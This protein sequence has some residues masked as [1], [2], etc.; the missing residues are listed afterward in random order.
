MV[1]SLVRI[2]FF[3]IF[4]FSFLSK[5]YIAQQYGFSTLNEHNGLSKNSVLGINQ[6]ANAKILLGTNDGGVN[7]VDG[8][9]VSYITINEGLVDNVIYDIVNINLARI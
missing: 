6:L 7:I 9:D 8:F 2:L 4:L 5:S 3:I 1:F